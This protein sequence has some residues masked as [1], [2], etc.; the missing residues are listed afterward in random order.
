[1][2]TNAERGGRTGNIFGGGRYGAG[3]GRH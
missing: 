1:V 2:N 3:R